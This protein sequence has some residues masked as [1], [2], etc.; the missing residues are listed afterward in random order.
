MEAFIEAN[1]SVYG[2]LAV[3]LL[4]LISGFGLALGEEMV[5]IPAGVFIAHGR[6]DFLTTALC[7]YV[8]IV[9]AD[10]IWYWICRHYG[11]P[12]LH[13]KWFKRLVHPRR[14]LEVKH[15]LERRG[16]WLIVMTRFI[17]SSRTTAIS[18]SG[19]FHMPYWKFVIANMCCVVFTVPLQLGVGYLL[20]SGMSAEK[21]FAEL[22]LHVLGIALA[23]VLVTLIIGWWTRYRFSRRRPPRAKASWLRR[24]RKPTLRPGTAGASTSETSGRSTSSGASTAREQSAP[25]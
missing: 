12:L 9:L 18:V 1:L 8:A 5:T 14:M 25:V 10:S 2:P 3:F 13:R 4:L 17:P 24:F 20:G 16:V 21:S 6:L 15:Q 11:T 23:I 22:L 19:M 7:A